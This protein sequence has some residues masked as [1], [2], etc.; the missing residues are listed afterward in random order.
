MYEDWEPD[1]Q[2]AMVYPGGV[3]LE[4]RGNI[5]VLSVYLYGEGCAPP[6]LFTNE[7]R[8]GMKKERDIE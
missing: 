5:C 3:K 7:I 8:Q 1:A 4:N 2:K 6:V